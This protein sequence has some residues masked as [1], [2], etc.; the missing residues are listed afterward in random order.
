LALV[1]PQRRLGTLNLPSR[2]PLDYDSQQ[3]KLLGEV[4]RLVAAALENAI[5]F[6]TVHALRSELEGDRDQ[7]RML[8]DVD[9]NLVKGRISLRACISR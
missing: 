1:S 2:T 3:M 8:L 5:D 4:G 6:E 7:L 9:P